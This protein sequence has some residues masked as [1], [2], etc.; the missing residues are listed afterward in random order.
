MVKV[1][2]EVG[3]KVVVDLTRV[4]VEFRVKYKVEVEFMHG[5][6]TELKFEFIYELV[7]LVSSSAEVNLKCKL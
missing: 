4:M 7:V 5:I 3:I 6:L 1:L 2:V